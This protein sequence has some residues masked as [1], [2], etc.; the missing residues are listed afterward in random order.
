MMVN[1]YRLAFWRGAQRCFASVRRILVANVMNRLAVSDSHR[2]VFGRAPYSKNPAARPRGSTLAGLSFCLLVTLAPGDASAYSITWWV[3]NGY[4]ADSCGPGDGAKT[5]EESCLAQFARRQACWPFQTCTLTGINYFTTGFAGCGHVGTAT[6]TEFVS[7][8]YWTCGSSAG[9]PFVNYSTQACS[10]APGYTWDPDHTPAGVPSPDGKG[11]CVPT[12]QTCPA[13]QGRVAGQCGHPRDNP[14]VGCD[15]RPGQCGTENPIDTASGQKRQTESLYQAAGPMAVSLSISYSSRSATSQFPPLSPTWSATFGS[16]WIGNWQRTIQGNPA[17]LSAGVMAQRADGAQFYFRPGAVA[18]TFISDDDIPDRLTRLNYPGGTPGAGWRYDDVRSGETEIYDYEGNLVQVSNRQGLLIRLAYAS[19]TGGVLYVDALPTYEPPG[20]VPPTCSPPASWIYQV[21]DAQP[22]A[23]VGNPQ[24]GRLL[25]VV[26]SSGRQLHFQTGLNGRIEKVADPA[27]GVYVFGYRGPSAESWAPAMPLDILSQVTFPDG[28]K[29]TYHYNERALINAGG[30]CADLP[31]AGLRGQLTGITNENN[32]RYVTWTY[33]C[34]GRATGSLNAGEVNRTTLAHDSPAAGKV[35]ATEYSGSA[36]APVATTRIY[37]FTEMFGVFKGSSVTDPGG[38]A[39]PCINCGSSGATTYDAK[40]Y[41]ASRRDWNGHLTCFLNDDRGQALVRVEGLSGSCPSNLQSTSVPAATPARKITT[42]WHPDYRLPTRI[43]EPL[44][45]TT[46]TYGAANA[47]NPGE[48]GNI[49]T[50]TVQATSDATGAAGFSATAVGAPRTTTYTWNSNGRMLTENGPRTDVSDITTYTYHSDTDPTIGRRGQIATVTNALGHVTQVTTYNAHG[51][52]TTVVDPNG[53]TT[54]LVYD[55]RQRLTSRTTAGEVT[56]YQYDNAGQLTRITQPDGAS[57]DFSY[58]AARRLTQVADNLGNRIAYTLDLRGNRVR[59]DVHDATGSLAQTRSRA[60]NA[61]NRLVQDIGAQNQITTYN[62]DAQGNL[63]SMSD[64]LGRV[65][66]NTYDALHRL[67]A[68]IQPIPAAGQGAPITNYA[69]NGQDQI[70]QVTD[71]RGLAT[72]Y[73]VNGHGET[74]QETSPDRGVTTRT[75]DDAGNL[76][77]STDARGKLTTMIYDA[78]NRPITAV[79]AGA[80]GDELASVTYQYDQG[81][82]GLG[83][84]TS[85][86]ETSAAGGILQTTSYTYD[87]LGRTLSETRLVA[88]SVTPHVIAY[89]YAPVTGRLTGMT[90]PSGRTLAFTYDAVG[91]VTQIAT[92]AATAQGGASQTIVSSVAY[93]P[94]GAPK[95]YLLGNARQV[96]RPHD[97]DGRIAGYTL[98]GNAYNLVYDPA[99]RITTL[100]DTVNAVQSQSYAY[101][102]LDRLTQASIPST[103]YSYAYDQTG[104]RTQRQA[105][106]AAAAYTI[107]PTSN[108]VTQINAASVR[109]IAYDT[110]GNTTN[111]GVNQYV[112]DTRGR[113]VQSVTSIGTTRYHIDPLGRRT[114]KTNTDPLIGDTVYHYDNAGRLIAETSPTGTTRREYFY[115]GDLPVGVY[116]Q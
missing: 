55:P 3:G 77:T 75:F 43:A 102:G 59:E 114:R 56:A 31:A 70:T 65:T 33:D 96:N 16:H 34:L 42:E 60:F 79:Y 116:A 23:S 19:G 74:T 1:G 13:G 105:G 83:R 6:C 47:S 100:F 39:A 111:D 85:A 38:Q 101:D 18:D 37:S 88:G 67:I 9:S 32:Q 15:K 84:L 48:R 53:V 80:T 89:Q 63:I 49:L 91:R 5:P 76:K 82:N 98:G 41:Y 103:N 2:R 35:T 68:V 51:Q 8:T 24:K 27:G 110:A 26:D 57:L 46:I 104:N 115:L 78:L 36:G 106:S 29:R 69:V 94:F 112:Y 54:Q 90:Y 58:D 87:G 86:V 14:G 66:T 93:H 30:A 95:A 12:P 28:T 20:Y 4:A 92:M 50:R 7:Y 21:N 72:A 109:S 44:K 113:L 64:P 61:L 40:G 22:P 73:V 62:H 99:G 81:A 108:R 11:A 71:P 25:C 45:I 97:Q 10:C 17:A 52:P 107:S